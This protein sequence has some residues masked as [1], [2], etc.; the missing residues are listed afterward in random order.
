MFEVDLRSRANIKTLD[1]Q[2]GD[3]VLIVGP[4]ETVD[5]SIDTMANRAATIPYELVCNFS[6]RMPR[7]YR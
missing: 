3:E 2:I 4:H 5:C 1:P 7:F 6:R